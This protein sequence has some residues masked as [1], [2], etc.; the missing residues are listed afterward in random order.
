MC[1]PTI[2]GSPSWL[3][4]RFPPGNLLGL[5]GWGTVPRNLW[6]CRDFWRGAVEQLGTLSR[7]CRV[8]RDMGSHPFFALKI[9]CSIFLRFVTTG[10]C[11]G[12]V[13]CLAGSVGPV[14]LLRV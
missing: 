4:G 13:R 7:V 9:V 1:S 2:L 3:W 10:V 11:A 6:P 8:S 5:E 12:G 14:F